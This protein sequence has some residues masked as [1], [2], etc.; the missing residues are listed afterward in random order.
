METAPTNAAIAIARFPASE[1]APQGGDERACRATSG[2]TKN[3]VPDSPIAAPLHREADE[4]AGQKR[5]DDPRHEHFEIQMR[6]KC[7]SACS[8]AS[9]FSAGTG[10]TRR[11]RPARFAARRV[12][13]P[14]TALTCAIHPVVG[15]KP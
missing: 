8:I 1:G 12:G 13:R 3:H 11:P 4:P 14:E 6:P 5:Y 7:R 15:T 2:Q 10:T 9:R